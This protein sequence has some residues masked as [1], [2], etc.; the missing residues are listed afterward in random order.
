M[1][2]ITREELIEEE[3]ATLSYALDQDQKLHISALINAA[4]GIEMKDKDKLIPHCSY[5]IP[6]LGLVVMPIRQ[7]QYPAG[8]E[9]ERPAQGQA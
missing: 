8:L 9:D 1:I 5:V 7:D 2:G 6:E 3:A 4:L